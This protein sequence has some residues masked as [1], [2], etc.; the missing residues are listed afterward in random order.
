[1]SG[2]LLDINST[3]DMVAMLL[4]VAGKSLLL[5]NVSVAEI[6]HVSEPARIEDVP[7][8]FAGTIVW[9]NIDIP[10]I[11]FEAI[12]DEPFEQATP[13]KRVAILN[14]SQDGSKLPFFAVVTQ[15]TPRMMRITP[16]EIANQGDVP[17][18]PAETMV[19]AISGEEAIIPNLAYIEN[20]L[21]RIMAEL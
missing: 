19:V 6:V 21:I 12:N 18:G 11:S 4:P 1:M 7:T 9:R 20:Q 13:D 16:Q 17:S 3:T 2:Q 14:G 10:L 8:W 5:P 15:G